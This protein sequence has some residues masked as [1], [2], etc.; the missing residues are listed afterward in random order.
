MKFCFIEDLTAVFTIENLFEKA[1]YF[2]IAQESI[3]ILVKFVVYFLHYHF[4]MDQALLTMNLG[5][6]VKLAR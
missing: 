2:V 6:L 4:N 3:S 5:F 1:F